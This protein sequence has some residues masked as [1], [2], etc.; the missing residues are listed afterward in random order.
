MS[1]PTT[2]PPLDLAELRRLAEDAATAEPWEYRREGDYWSIYPTGIEGK[3]NGEGPEEVYRYIAVVNP[4]TLLALLDRLEGAEATVNNVFHEDALKVVSLIEGRLEIDH[5]ACR[6]LVASFADT[7]TESGATNC[8]EVGF[9]HPE[10]GRLLVTVQR[11]EGKTPMDLKAEVEAE[12]D[13]LRRLLGLVYGRCLGGVVPCV[14]HPNHD[15]ILA[16]L[17]GKG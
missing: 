10:L 4:A 15:E 1:D 11:A 9:D 2:T 12:R 8:L 17:E 7:F 5:W 16:A 14:R 3:D 6:L 13:N